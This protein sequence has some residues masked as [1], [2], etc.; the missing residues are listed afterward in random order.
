MCTQQWIRALGELLLKRTC[1]SQAQTLEELVDGSCIDVDELL[2]ARDTLA[3]DC[4][5]GND[6]ARFQHSS[7]QG[8]LNGTV[9]LLVLIEFG[10]IMGGTSFSEGASPSILG[11][12]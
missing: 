2:Q 11:F 12:F 6:P 8:Y 5:R 3:A 1:F 4:G 7:C 10:V 9:T